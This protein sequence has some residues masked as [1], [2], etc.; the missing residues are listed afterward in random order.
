MASSRHEVAIMAFVGLA[1]LALPLYMEG[2]SSRHGWRDQGTDDYGGADAQ[3]I[4]ANSG[5]GAPGCVGLQCAVN[6]ECP[7]GGHT[8]ISGK[9]YDPAGVDG[10]RGSAVPGVPLYN[11]V[12]FVPTDPAGGLPRIKPG[13]SRT[14]CNTCD[15][16]I[17]DIVTSAVTDATGSFQ[18][19]DVPTGTDVPLVMQIGKWRREIKVPVV[20]D[21]ADTRPD[22]RELRLPRNQTEGDIPQMALL[23]GGCDP[24]GC[25][26]PRIGLDR[27]EIT[28]PDGEGRMHVYAGAGGGGVL[29]GSAPDCSGPDCPLWRSSG[30]PGLGDY[31]I[32]VFS[33]ECAPNDRGPAA[34]Q[35]LHDWLDSGGKAFVT[36]YHY[37]WF[38]GSPDPAF[39]SIASWDT[40]EQYTVGAP[41]LVD[42]TFSK[43]Q[44]FAAWLEDPAVGA[45]DGTTYSGAPSFPLIDLNPN[46][47]REDLTTVSSTA[48]RWVWEPPGSIDVADTAQPETDKFFSFETPLDAGYADVTAPDGA[49]QKAYCGKAVY[50][51]I[52]VGGT[53]NASTLPSTCDNAE[54]TPQERALEFLFFDLSACVSEEPLAPPPP[55]R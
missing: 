6:H 29:S 50:S 7:A 28:G 9:V 38:T 24:F 19:V 46:D 34:D 12:V 39:R 31:D 42:N 4:G 18:L 23:T 13:T 36:H 30:S 16:D 22:P 14:G 45:I 5:N 52:H 27:N 10:V 2:C 35:A 44:A 20:A 48:T 51:D 54:L 49:P 1:L 47:V 33:C 37:T 40:A 43:G 21:C 17:G 53:E 55:P 32:V 8:T 26:F 11:V 41:F 15:A 3:A 25:L